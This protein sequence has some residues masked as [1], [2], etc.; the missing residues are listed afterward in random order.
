MN[1]FVEVEWIFL[2][3]IN[4]FVE[5]EWIFLLNMNLLK[6]NEYFCWIWINLLKL[7]EFFVEFWNKSIANH[8]HILK[9]FFVFNMCNYGCFYT[10]FIKYINFQIHCIVIWG[11]LIYNHTQKPLW[12]QRKC[13]LC[14]AITYRL[15]LTFACSPKSWLNLK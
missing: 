12:I 5:F 10:L 3:N 2:L 9:S 15:Q 11:C 14:L 8:I 6:L 7:N 4:K 1:K 13:S